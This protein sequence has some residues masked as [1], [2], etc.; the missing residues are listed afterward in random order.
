MAGLWVFLTTG[1]TFPVMRIIV[2][3]GLYWDLLIWG[4]CVSRE[5]T[6]LHV[7]TAMLLYC[8]TP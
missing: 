4:N 2:L 8:E 3:W 5:I 6:E 7:D 1:G